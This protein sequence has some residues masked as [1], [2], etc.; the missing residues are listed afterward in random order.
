MALRKLVEEARRNGGGREHIRI[1]REAAYRFLA[2]M[3]GDLPCYEEALR[4]LFAGDRAGFETI[5]GAWPHDVR[6]YGLILADG[7][8]K[9][10]G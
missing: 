5:T 7:S 2:A 8:W 4:A 10:E 1:R 9:G 6:D 3:A